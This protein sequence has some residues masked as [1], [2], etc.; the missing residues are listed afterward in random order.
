MK[1][2]TL[3]ETIIALAVITTGFLGV[4]SLLATTQASFS[5]IRDGLVAAA[6]TQEGIELTR[7]IRDNNWLA[8]RSWTEGILQS[9][10]CVD[11]D[12]AT[13]WS[14]GDNALYFDE[15]RG[16]F[17]HSAVGEPTVFSRSMNANLV[18]QDELRIVTTVSWSRRGIPFSFAV[19]EHLF[20]W[21]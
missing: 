20:N 21:K 19:E 17:T 2:F 1:G 6:M 18:S 12:R 5:L 3:I 15:G 8:R 9:G 10:S 11:I 4:L 7:N 14:C 16:V 13:F